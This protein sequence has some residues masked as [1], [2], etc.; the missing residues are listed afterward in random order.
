MAHPFLMPLLSLLLGTLSAYA[1]SDKFPLEVKSAGLKKHYSST[2][3][4][5]GRPFFLE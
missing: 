4:T 3:K 1:V 2:C 5:S